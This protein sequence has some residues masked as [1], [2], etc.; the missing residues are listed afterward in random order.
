MV[1]R[2]P[3]EA[4]PSGEMN[5][6]WIISGLPAGR[7]RDSRSFKRRVRL[8]QIIFFF[9]CRGSEIDVSRWL[10][11]HLAAGPSAFLFLSVFNFGQTLLKFLCFNRP[12]TDLQ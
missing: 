5:R 4:L 3:S 7:N 9:S 12:S 1:N 11:G 10:L 2:G 6:T 8:L